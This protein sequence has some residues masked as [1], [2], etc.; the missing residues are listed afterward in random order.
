MDKPSCNSWYVLVRQFTGYFE[1][2]EKYIY[3]DTKDDGNRWLRSW[4]DDEYPDI[5][6][7]KYGTAHKAE[8]GTYKRL[9]SKIFP[10]P[11]EEDD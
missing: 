11:D 6:P 2:S 8:D 4:Y 9:T 10:I 1:Y 7:L 5:L 3:F